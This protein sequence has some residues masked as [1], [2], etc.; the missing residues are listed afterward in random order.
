MKLKFACII[1]INLYGDL[2][3]RNIQ[4]AICCIN[5]CSSIETF[6]KR[7][8]HNILLEMGGEKYC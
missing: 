3:Y 1:R 6:L 5:K 7:T 2:I 4:N 8:V